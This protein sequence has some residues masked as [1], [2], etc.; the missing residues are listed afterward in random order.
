MNPREMAKFAYENGYYSPEGTSWSLWTEGVGRLGLFGEMLPLSESSMKHALDTG[1]LIVCS[2]RPGDFTTVGH[3]ILIRGYDEKGFY[4]NDPNR[5]S[6]SEKQCDF[7]SL[8]GQIK[9]LWCI[10]G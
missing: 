4:V 1:S 7:E 9:N 5:R 3:F 2:M 6:N 8:N 10:H